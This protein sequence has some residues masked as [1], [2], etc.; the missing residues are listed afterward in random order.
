MQRE[1]SRIPSAN[2]GVPK[3]IAMGWYP[4]SGDFGTHDWVG[5][6]DGMLVYIFALGSTT[7]GVGNAAWYEVWA[8]VL[9]TDWVRYYGPAMSQFEPLFGVLFSPFWVALQLGSLP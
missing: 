9:E 5:Y 3:V 6:N 2:G 7:H 1:N 4:E 8:A